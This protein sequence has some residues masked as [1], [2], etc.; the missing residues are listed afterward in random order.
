MYRERL[1]GGSLGTQWFGYYR[2]MD[3]FFPVVPTS[4]DTVI[5]YTQRRVVWIND[6]LA[7]NGSVDSM[8]LAVMGHSNGARGSRYLMKVY[9]QKF[10]SVA[11]FTSITRGGDSLAS[12]TIGNAE[13]NLPT[14]LRD[15]NGQA[16]RMNQLWDLTSTFAPARDLPL[17]RLFAGKRD[18]ENPNNVWDA[19]L[20]GQLRKEGSL[21]YGMHIYWDERR[22]GPENIVPCHWVNST[23]PLDQ[24][25][26]DNAAYQFRYRSNQSFPAFYRHAGRPGNRDPGNGVPSNGDPWGTWGGYHD[27]DIDTI[28]DQPGRWEVTAFLVGLSSNTVD[29]F[30]GPGN[31]LTADLAIRRPQQFKPKMGKILQWSV[32]RLSNNQVLQSG[33]TTV[34]AEGLVSITGITVFKDPDLVRIRVSDP[35]VAV[36]SRDSE[37]LPTEFSLSQNYPNPFNPSTVISFQL[38]VNSHVTLKVFDVN[39]REVATLADGELRSGEHVVVF[40]A[41]NLPS[42]VYIYRVQ[43]GNFVEQKKMEVI[44]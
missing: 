19:S 8:R 29:N 39:G 34:G 33:T 38:P 2:R 7:R 6:W 32:T 41:N 15:R 44:K 13:M 31:S 22:H 35:T 30:P 23:A 18:L 36:E 25:Q 17:T 26:R 20:V 43:A 4:A 10:S 5:N 12:N 9:P 27:W 14:N 3:A 1:P 28:V 37:T 42:G 40:D 11:M 16:V 21:S 24:T